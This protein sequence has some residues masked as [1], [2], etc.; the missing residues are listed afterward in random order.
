[1][2]KW[3]LAQRALLAIMAAALVIGLVATPKPRKASV[4][5]VA[6]GDPNALSYTLESLD[7]NLLTPY[8]ADLAVCGIAPAKPADLS[9]F[10]EERI[11][12]RWLVHEPENWESAF[13]QM[14]AGDR[15]TKG[16][17]SFFFFL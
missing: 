13:N 10:V 4:L 9:A 12:F 1:M 16:S 14:C 11:K 2:P 6:L 3:G 7:R 17:F 8:D 15:L 5:V